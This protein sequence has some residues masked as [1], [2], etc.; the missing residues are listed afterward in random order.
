MWKRYDCPTRPRQLIFG[1]GGK[2]QFA[3]GIFITDDQAKQEGLESSEKFGVIIHAGATGE[4]REE[5]GP[6]PATIQDHL[7]AIEAER[8]AA[9]PPVHLSP[10][11]GAVRVVPK[12]GDEPPPSPDEE[13]QPDPV[14]LNPEQRIRF[15]L[16]GAGFD[17]GADIHAVCEE[18]GIDVENLPP[19]EVADAV[20]AKLEPLASLP[21][22]KK[23][24]APP[25]APGK[26]EIHRMKHDDLMN[27][28]KKHKIPNTLPI[29]A[30][31]K[32]LRAHVYSHFYGFEPTQEPP[33]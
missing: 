9:S 4:I 18:M 17:K 25:D 31:A 22:P 32:R 19:A 21:P 7:D 10:L 26:T 3:N 13:E 28:A 33:G 1:P 2:K 29:M 15:A 11:E 23:P 6:A 5:V 24:D 14:K 27:I 12:E 20:E 30:S 16:L 8:K